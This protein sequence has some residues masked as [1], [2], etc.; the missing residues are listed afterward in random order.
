MSDKE[1]L[2]QLVEVLEKLT[3]EIPEAIEAAYRDG[4]NDGDDDCLSDEC[5]RKS[6]TKKTLDL[7]M[8]ERGGLE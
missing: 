6:D 8:K 7:A 3:V 5:W 4:L 2:N 1:M